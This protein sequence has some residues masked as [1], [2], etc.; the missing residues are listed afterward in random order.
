[1]RYKELKFQGNTYEKEYQIN[2]ILIKNNITWLIEAEIEN[3]RFRSRSNNF[4]IMVVLPHPEGAEI[5]I[6]LFII[7][8]Y[9]I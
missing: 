5:I 1:M 6:A 8:K 2:E 4:F 9:K 3:A 7:Y